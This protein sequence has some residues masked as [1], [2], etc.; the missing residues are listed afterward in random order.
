MKCTAYHY[1]KT[2]V[3]ILLSLP[4]CPLSSFAQGHT[5]NTSITRPAIF[6]EG[7]ISTV[8]GYETHPAFSPSGDTVYFLR[9]APDLSSSAIYFSIK[10]NDLWM[11]PEL[12]PFSGSYFD[13]DPFVT[14]DGNSIYFTSNR[15]VHAGDTV[16]PDT[17]IWKIERNRSG[18]WGDP[19]HLDPPLNSNGDEHYPTIADNGNMYFGSGRAGGIGGS[20]I[21]FSKFVNGS[22]SLPKMLSDAV[23]TSYNEYEPFIAKDE[24]YI[25]FMA[26]QPDGLANADLYIS[27]NEQGEWSKSIK[28]PS[29]IN[30]STTE[31]APKISGDGNNF[32]FGST[33]TRDQGNKKNAALSDIYHVDIKA[34]NLKKTLPVSKDALKAKIENLLKSLEAKVGLSILHIETK[35]TLSYNGNTRLPMLSVYKFPIAMAVLNEVDKGRLKMEQQVVIAKELIHPGDL[36]TFSIKNFPQGKV[37]IETLLSMMLV[38]GSNT[39]CDILLKEMNGPE[40]VQQYVQQLG[41]GNMIIASSEWDIQNDPDI[42][43]KNWSTANEMVKL[44]AIANKKNVLSKSSYTFLWEKMTATVTGPNRIKGMLPKDT[45]VAHRTGTSGNGYNDA[46]IITLPGGDHIAIA[47]FISEVKE[48]PATCDQVIAQISKLMYDYY[49][50]Q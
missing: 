19:V 7:I 8:E 18:S 5:I 35:D 38:H 39:A 34:L 48:Y 47:V 10:K 25:I 15:P 50:D 32:Y 20:D 27:Y 14:K 11:R 3:M 21:Y 45:P 49:S 16:R 2:G 31:W 29:S 28:L 6:A 42:K 46:G 1:L 22:L 40:A 43:Y 36:E 26:T 37:T 9:C 44:L 17:D 33:R 23:N 24:S 41:I 4:G 12:A 13:A 30:S